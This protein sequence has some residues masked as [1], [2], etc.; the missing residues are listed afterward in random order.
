LYDIGAWPHRDKEEGGGGLQHTYRLA[1]AQGVCCRR[2]VGRHKDTG[3]AGG[4]LA[5][6]V[7]NRQ[8]AGAVELVGAQWAG[9]PDYGPVST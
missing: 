7:F 2:C 8:T 6:S 3:T 9:V 1:D 5:E 4:R